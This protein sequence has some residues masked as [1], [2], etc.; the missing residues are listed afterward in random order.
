[1]HQGLADSVRGGC[2]RCH[3]LGSL[4]FREHLAALLAVGGAA[5]VPGDSFKPPALPGSLVDASQRVRAVW[6]AAR[7]L[8][9]TS[10]ERYLVVARG[11]VGLGT[12]PSAIRVLSY[13]DVLSLELR[14]RVPLGAASLLVYGFRACGEPDYPGLQLEAVNADGVRLEFRRLRASRVSLAGCT[15]R[16]GRRFDVRLGD[17]DHL[18]LVEGPVSALCA[19][20]RFGFLD[21]RWGVAGVAGWAGFTPAVAGR[22]SRVVLCADGDRDGRR[23]VARLAD[24]LRSEGRTVWVVDSPDG[25]DVA[26]MWV[27]AGSSTWRPD[28]HD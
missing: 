16:G 17:G 11:C 2:R 13:A 22:A 23:A 18:L 20:L 6:D 19:P 1:M 9:G 27:R 26:D 10:A 25:R 15:F 7:P 12:W 24:V 28:F 8:P 21:A 5:P 14:P 4:G 3:P